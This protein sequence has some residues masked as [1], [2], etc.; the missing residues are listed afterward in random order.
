MK[1]KKS[2]TDSIKHINFYKQIIKKKSFKI[3]KIM[4]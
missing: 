1:T 3:N 4:Q 2:Q